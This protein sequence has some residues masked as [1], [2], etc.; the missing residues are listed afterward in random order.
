[1]QLLLGAAIVVT[2]SGRQ[3]PSSVIGHTERR[4]WKQSVTNVKLSQITTSNLYRKDLNI[5]SKIMF[6]PFMKTMLVVTC[7][8][9]GI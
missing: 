8:R 3:K 2:S 6:Q 4:H 1:M 9:N 5:L 7:F